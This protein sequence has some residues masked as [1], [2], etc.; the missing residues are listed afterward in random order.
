MTIL[1]TLKN[2]VQHAVDIVVDQLSLLNDASWISLIVPTVAV[3]TIVIY[4]SLRVVLLPRIPCDKPYWALGHLGYVKNGYTLFMYLRDTA[5]KYPIS[6]FTIGPKRRI[7][8]L[9]DVDAVDAM[10]K[11]RNWDAQKEREDTFGAIIPAGLIA[12]RGVV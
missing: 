4:R 7:I 5:E 2:T 12:I 11:D 8:L 10:F 1:S 6:Q 3:S 9:G